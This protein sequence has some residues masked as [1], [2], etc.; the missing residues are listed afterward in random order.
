MKCLFVC[1]FFFSGYGHAQ[2]Q[3]L[4]FKAASQNNI[5]ILPQKQ[6]ESPQEALERY[7][8]SISSHPELQIVVSKKQLD[9]FQLQQVKNYSDFHNRPSVLI[10]ANR[11]YDQTAETKEGSQKRIKNFVAQFKMQNNIFVL[12]V[13]A[14]AGLS[15]LE[16]IQ[17]HQLLTENLNG[18]LALGGADISPELYN[19]DVIESRDMNLARDSHE[20]AFLKY[21]ISAK[22]GFL[23]GVCRGHQLI[24]AALGFKL[25]QH[26]DLHGDGV[27]HSHLIYLMKTK[28]NRFQNLFSKTEIEV[29]SYHHQAVE[30]TPN[31]NV[32]VAARAADGTVESLESNDGLILT[33]QFHPE[34]MNTNVS[35]KIFRMLNSILWGRYHHQC[36]RI[37]E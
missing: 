9:F 34:F 23:F 24:A 36:K 5:F 16:T 19:E 17:F 7:K 26:I 2:I 35:K 3:L 11:G 29:N 27:W 1:L 21:W 30:Y 12:P 14:S 8:E 13:A 33:T 22:K 6:N 28:L 31:E 15:E 18:V 4:Y 20:I 10:L 25:I 32:Q 37:F